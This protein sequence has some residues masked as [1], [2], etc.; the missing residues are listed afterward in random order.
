ML[1]YVFINERK[2]DTMSFCDLLL[3]VFHFLCKNALTVRYFYLTAPLC[4]RKIV[5]PQT[6]SWDFQSIF[7]DKFQDHQ[8]EDALQCAIAADVLPLDTLSS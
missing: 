8:H 5:Q 3:I 2:V 7:E 4:F 1:G 6:Q